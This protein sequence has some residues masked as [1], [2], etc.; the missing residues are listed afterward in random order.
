MADDEAPD[1]KG[2]RLM[3]IIQSLIAGLDPQKEATIR[4]ASRI[5]LGKI[6]ALA[7]QQ[8]GKVFD[9]VIRARVQ[10]QQALARGQPPADG[11]PT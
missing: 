9:L 6:R 3:R 4:E 8:R 5:A 10:E 2:E 7:R 11:E 1:P